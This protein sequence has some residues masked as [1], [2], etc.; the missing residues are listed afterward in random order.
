[1]PGV[2]PPPP[3]PHDQ[4]IKFLPSGVSFHLHIMIFQYPMDIFSNNQL[5]ILKKKLVITSTGDQN[6]EFPILED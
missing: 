2:M 6:E 5:K 3:P 4:V 1:M